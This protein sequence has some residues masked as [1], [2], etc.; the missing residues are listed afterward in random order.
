MAADKMNLKL[1]MHLLML[2]E[3]KVGMMQD[4]PST[5]AHNLALSILNWK[6]NLL[7]KT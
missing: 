2:S 5:H 4:F 6:S 1:N 3:L 7:N